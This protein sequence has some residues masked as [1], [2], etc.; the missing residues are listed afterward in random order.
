MDSTS[1]RN[2]P[3]R[4]P[5]VHH[6]TRR[7]AA[8][9]VLSVALVSSFAAPTAAAATPV[10]SFRVSGTATA[11]CATSGD[12]C[13]LGSTTTSDYNGTTGTCTGT[14]CPSTV[15][16]IDLTF[17]FVKFPP[18]PCH[19][20]KVT[21]TLTLEYPAD[22]IFPPQPMRVSVSGHLRDDHSVVL[23]GTVPTDAPF[24]PPVPMRVIVS[25]SF[26]PNPCTPNTGT[27]NGS[28]TIG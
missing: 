17:G 15:G 22:P 8:A 27:F 24:Y 19:T 13:L 26:P 2:A 9:A 14:N 6:R 28:I 1:Y 16:T 10:A 5:R 11:A 23:T 18:N 21:G 20:N 25:P 3:V 7:V 4:S 12:F